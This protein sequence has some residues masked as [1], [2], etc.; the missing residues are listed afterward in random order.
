MG[1]R[2]RQVEVKEEICT[3]F[4]GL[5]K[6]SRLAKNSFTHF[7]VGPTPFSL[8]TATLCR[9]GVNFHHFNNDMTPHSSSTK[10]KTH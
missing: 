10:T 3:Q 1:R 9:L 8:I 6:H 2:G 4:F 7:D 5:C